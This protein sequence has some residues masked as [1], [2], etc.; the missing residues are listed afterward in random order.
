M[1]RT[2]HVDIHDAR[3]MRVIRFYSVRFSN[4]GHTTATT[5]NGNDFTINQ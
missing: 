1:F 5:G 4:N 2:C 3:E